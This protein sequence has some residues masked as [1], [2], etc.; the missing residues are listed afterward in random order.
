MIIVLLY[1]QML[2][3]LKRSTDNLV[4]VIGEKAASEQTF[5]VFKYDCQCVLHSEKKL[6]DL[7]NS[8]N[9]FTWVSMV[10]SIQIAK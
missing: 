2:P 4:A 10:L 7:V 9:Q 5:E 3:L 1:F 8:V 6:G